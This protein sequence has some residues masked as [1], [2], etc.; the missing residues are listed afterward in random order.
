M[1]STKSKLVLETALL[2]ATTAVLYF[3]LFYFEDNVLQWCR[4]FKKDGWYFLAPILIALVFSAA[5][6]AFTS[7]FWRLLGIRA[8]G[9]NKEQ[10]VD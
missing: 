5:H 2:G 10:A 6:G 8:K 1:E 9:N 7:N 4:G 3:L